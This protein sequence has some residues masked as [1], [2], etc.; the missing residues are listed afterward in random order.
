MARIYKIHPSIGIARVGQSKAGFFLAPEKLDG[1][2]HEIGNSNDIAFAGF[3]DNQYLVRRQAA[4]FRVYEY[5]DDGAGKQTL[6]GEVKPEQATIRWTVKLASSKAAG[7]VMTEHRS[8]LQGERVIAPDY[9]GPLRN[10]P[11]Q[12]FTQDDLAARLRFD[13]EG[14]NQA[15]AAQMGKI[16]GKDIF[17]GE[18]KTDHSGRLIVLG[19]FGVAVSWKN[20]PPKFQNFL[21]NATW[22]DDIADGPVDAVLVS[23]TGET[24]PHQV[25]GAWVLVAPPDFAPDIAP[26]VSLYD[27]MFDAMVRDNRLARPKTSFADDILPILQRVANLKWTNGNLIWARIEAACANSQTLSDPSNANQPA[28]QK[29]FDL[30]QAIVDPNDE[31]LTD[32]RFTKTQLAALND[33]LVGGNM[34][35]PGSDPNRPSLNEAE[36]LDKSVLTATIGSGFYP[37]IECGFTSTRP[38][39]YVEPFR[40][41]R[42]QFTDVD[43]NK[44]TPEPGFFTQRMACPWQADFTECLRSWWPAQRPDIALFDENMAPVEQHFWD[45]GIIVGGDPHKAEESKS[46]EN[47]IARVH[48]LGVIEKAA[49]GGRD[50]FRE[51]GRDPA[52]PETA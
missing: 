20:P 22:Y 50:I 2:R 11:P 18:V 24:L 37:G 19:G 14:T 8:D 52:L 1:A 32:F 38:S 3:K 23:P 41:T 6:V 4:R 21:N 45:R 47:M 16:V 25:T 35:L 31:V 42:N 30:L 9:S 40:F 29:V 13:V 49:V 34:F 48:K 28:R 5:E 44:R 33:W 39:L 17:I 46:K 36:E 12:G 10:R 26:V 51:K 15:A 7:P 27:V 43:G